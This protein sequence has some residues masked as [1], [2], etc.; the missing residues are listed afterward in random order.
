MPGFE[1]AWLSVAH[2]RDGEFVSGA[3]RPLLEDVYSSVLATPADLLALKSGLQRLLEYL[4]GDGRTNANCY[5][6]DLFF[7][8][9]RGWERD[10]PDQGLPD[11]F[12]DLLAMMGEALHDTVRAPDVAGNFDCLPEQLLER[13]KRLGINGRIS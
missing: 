6:V 12:H 13:V 1:E 5:A 3:L 7:G 10:W 9:S 11:D 2:P 8:E 4:A